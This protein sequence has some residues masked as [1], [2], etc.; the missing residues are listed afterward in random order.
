MPDNATQTHT[1]SPAQP[2]SGGRGIA[3]PFN[4]LAWCVEKAKILHARERKANIPVSVAITHIGYGATSSS[5][6]QAVSALLQF[7]LVE[8]DGLKDTRV[9]RL[10]ERALDIVLAQE[11][12]ESKRA[13]LKFCARAPK[14]YS[15]LLARYVDGLPS[16]STIKFFL[17]KEKDFNPKTVDSFIA[18]FRSSLAYA[19]VDKPDEKLDGKKEKPPVVV[20]FGIGDFVQWESNGVLGFPAPR[21]V[22]KF[23][24]DKTHAWVEGSNT[25]LPTT[26][27]QKV[28]E[29][30]PSGSSALIAKLPPFQAI[31]I[32]GSI[33]MRQEVITLDE[34]EAIVAWPD[35]I[36]LESFGDFEYAVQGM[37]KKLKRRIE[38]KATKIDGASQGDDLNN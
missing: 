16:D 29:S 13:A 2:K 9:I 12:S 14:I 8:D 26:E 3:Y 31:S 35:T 22:I 19:G 33:Q 32:Q 20:Q 36:S 4:D 15:E 17:Q 1:I 23:S 10:T 30:K 25:G 34:G 18:D 28:E 7:G 37:L 5:G 21:K 24:D 11:E 38:S 27:L 6:R